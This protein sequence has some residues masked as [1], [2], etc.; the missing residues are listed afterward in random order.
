[1]KGRG[2]KLV[3]FVV[4]LIAMSMLLTRC[5]LFRTVNI[6]I[7]YGNEFYVFIVR[8]GYVY[9]TWGMYHKTIDEAKLLEVLGGE[10]SGMEID[11]AKVLSADP[12]NNDVYPD[13]G[14]LVLEIY[15]GQDLIDQDIAPYGTQ[16]AHLEY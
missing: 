10:L 9:I 2:I 1:M 11:V 13:A 4:L 16:W 5:D 15:E 7:D 3:L 6:E 14:D 8:P 12:I